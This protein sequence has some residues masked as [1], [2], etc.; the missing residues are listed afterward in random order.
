MFSRAFPPRLH[1]RDN[2]LDPM[3]TERDLRELG[4]VPAASETTISFPGSFRYFQNWKKDPGNEVGEIVFPM[5]LTSSSSSHNRINITEFGS[6]RKQREVLV[7]KSQL[8]KLI[9][10]LHILPYLFLSREDYDDVRDAGKRD[11][12]S[13]LLYPSYVI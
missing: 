13:V 12:R 10:R 5:S 6:C 9:N 11:F 4:W 3:A 8:K 1:I 7:N 2:H